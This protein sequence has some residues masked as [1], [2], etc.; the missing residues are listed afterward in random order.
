MTGTH[1]RIRNARYTK[2]ASHRFAI[3]TLKNIP[4]AE[5]VTQLIAGNMMKKRKPS[6]KLQFLMR[7]AF[8][9]IMVRG[10][11]SNEALDLSARRKH[12]QIT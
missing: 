7:N 8:S 1:D 10:S 2:Y 3:H 11:I 4:A 12:L 5:T 6:M 9:K